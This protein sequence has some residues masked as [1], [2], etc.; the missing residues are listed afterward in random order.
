MKTK[1]ECWSLGNP[2]KK[3]WTFSQLF[4]D[5]LSLVISRAHN[6]THLEN[7]ELGLESCANKICLLTYIDFFNHSTT[8][9]A[10]LTLPLT[11]ATDNGKQLLASWPSCIQN[12]PEDD[13]LK[14]GPGSAVFACRKIHADEEVTIS[15][16]KQSN[17]ELLTRYG[18]SVPPNSEKTDSAKLIDLDRILSK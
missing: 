10:Q 15:Y 14:H 8:P 1:P 12:S 18:F 6:F 4:R 16:G 13:L 9:N 5:E 3:D 2:E 11:P 17:T 7:T